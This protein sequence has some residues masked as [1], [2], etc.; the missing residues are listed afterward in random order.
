MTSAAAGAA[1]RAGELRRLIGEHNHRY[2]VL[3]DPSVSDAAF[4]ALMTELQQLE[5]EY[6]ELVVPESPTQRVAAGVSTGFATVAH[7][8]PMLSLDNAFGEAPL[9][10]WEARNR[11]YLGMPGDAPFE[12]V[13]ELKID[14]ASISLHYEHGKLVRAL[15][16]G[17]GEEGEEITANARAIATIP[18]QLLE[19]SVPPPEF[20]EV[21]G[22]VYLTFEEFARINAGLEEGGGK[23]FANPRNAAAGSLRQRD[24]ALTAH[25]RLNTFMYTLGAVDGMAFDAQWQLLET[26]REWGLRTNPNVRLCRGI[27]EVL[28]FC[29]E[30]AVRKES[31]NYDIDGVVVKVNAFAVQAELGAASRSPRWAIAYKGYTPNQARTVVEEIAV[32][33]GRLGTL[34]PVAHLRPVNVGGVTV[35]R[36]TLHNEDEIRRKDVRIGDTVVVQRAGEVIPEVVEVVV[37]ARTGAEREFRMPEECPVCRGEVE[38]AAGEAVSRCINVSCPAQIRERIR[39]FVSRNAMDIEGL[40]DKHIDQLV[41]RG[42]IAS[43]ADIYSLTLEKLGPLERMGDRLAASILAAIQAGKR[44][45]L[46][47]LLFAVGIRHVGEGGARALAR[48]FGSLEA[49]RDASEEQL[50]AVPDIG[51]TTAA[52]IRHFFHDPHNQQ[53]IAALEEAGVVPEAQQRAPESNRFAGKTFVFTGTLQQLKREDAE[54]I[55]RQHGGNASGSVSKQTSCVVAGEKAGSKLDKAR[56][57]GVEVITEAEF[58]ERVQRDDAS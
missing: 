28:A 25:R 21:R 51:P 13:A 41:T 45:P 18:L 1:A 47:R 56:S 54:E 58:L 26:Y 35:S 52:S 39:H 50:A 43:A 10:A 8:A 20:I 57:L 33:V 9:R 23:T 11:T 6:P 40:G 5:A 38:R 16:R 4:D 17:N 29:D 19:S 44:R 32:Q 53:L 36:A 22:E 34:T 42:I 37:D 15:T 3:D 27:D 31:L 49:V 12:Y 46:Q 7:R 2:Y 14:G 55:V 30:W 24:P 48:A